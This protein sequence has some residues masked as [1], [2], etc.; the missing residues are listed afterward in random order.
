MMQKRGSIPEEQLWLQNLVLGKF[1]L[2]RTCQVKGKGF[3]LQCTRPEEVNQ[4][5]CSLKP[6]ATL[7]RGLPKSLRRIKVCERV[8]E[9]G[10][11]G[12]VMERGERGFPS[13][14]HMMKKNKYQFLDFMIKGRKDK[15]TP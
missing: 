7:N 12:R 15:S 9:G 11:G 1:N 6:K 14:S 10:A 13:C 4:Y 8:C 3:L 2:E 5:K